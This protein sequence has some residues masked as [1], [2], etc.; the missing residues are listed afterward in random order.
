[1]TSASK[2]PVMLRSNSRCAVYQRLS[3]EKNVLAIRGTHEEQDI[4]ADLD[5]FVT[6][7][8]KD[9]L[10]HSLLHILY[11]LKKHN[12]QAITGHSL[13][14]YRIVPLLI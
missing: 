3:D 13:G 7:A 9:R 2:F 12:I 4:Q 14:G 10:E 6:F 1:M 8:G 5:F 11:L